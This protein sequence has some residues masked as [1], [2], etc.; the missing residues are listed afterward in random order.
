LPDNQLAAVFDYLEERYEQLGLSTWR[1]EFVWRGMPQTNLV[2]V[3]PG[4]DGR[5]APL[6]IADHVDTAFDEDLALKGIW[7]AVPGA[8]DN[9]TGTAALLRAADVLRDR[10]PRRTIWLVHFTGEEFPA[11]DWAHVPS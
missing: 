9:A 3:I 4:S 7:M 5:L 8:D 1:Q 2:A 6:L 11:D 10:D